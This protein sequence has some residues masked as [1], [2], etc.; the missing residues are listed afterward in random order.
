M[1]DLTPRQLD[2]LRG[3]ANG[4]QYK[5]MCDRLGMSMGTLK[6]HVH[7]MLD[8]LGARNAAQAV[9]IGMRRGIL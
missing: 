5:M 1:R 9:A 2:V 7:S 8:R 3:M 6:T 4:E